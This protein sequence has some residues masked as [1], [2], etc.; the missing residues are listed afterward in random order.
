MSIPIFRDRKIKFH[1]YWK[2]FL[3][4]ITYLKQNNVHF[5]LFGFSWGLCMYCKYL[6]MIFKD[7]DQNIFMQFSLLINFLIFFT[8]VR[9]K[10][11]DELTWLLSEQFMTFC[12]VSSTS[13]FMRKV[14]CKGYCHRRR[15]DGWLFLTNLIL[16]QVQCVQVTSISLHPLLTLPI[17]HDLF[18]K[19]IF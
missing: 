16:W 7:L 8:N 11:F 5:F 12:L 1:F 17:W 2:L 15:R 18:L 13:L 10:L 4:V 14:F 3:C 9:I 19:T 6:K